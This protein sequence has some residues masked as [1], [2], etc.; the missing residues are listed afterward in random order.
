[1]DNKDNN[2]TAQKQFFIDSVA[3]FCDKC[4]TAYTTDDV[5]ILQ[6]TNLATIIHFT[7]NKCKAEH[8]ATF[9]KGLG[10][11]QKVPINT[12]LTA[13]EVQKFS[14]MGRISLQE[15]LNLYKFLKENSS[16]A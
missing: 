13:K 8:I 1:M 3:K 9:M 10:I 11:S 7:C 14:E 4:S 16:E 15:V 12:D 6:N 5:N 2:T